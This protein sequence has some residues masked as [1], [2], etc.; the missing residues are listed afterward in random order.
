[1]QRFSI[2]VPLLDDRRLFD[3]TLAS[4]LRYRPENSQI[5][6]PHDGTYDDPFDLDG[7]VEFVSTAHR[8]NQV[9]LFNIAVNKAAGDYIAWIRP[10]IEL[11]SGW[12]EHV[13]LKFDNTE[14]ASVTPIIVSPAHPQR[15]VAA[16]VNTG[17]G[18]N[19]QVAGSRARLAPRTFRRISAVGPTSW[20]AFYRKSALDQIGI[21]AEQIDPH[22]LDVDIAMSLRRIGF[23]SELCSDC[24]LTI[25]RA[26][27]LERESSV[28]H[29]K[30]AQRGYYRYADPSAPQRSA[31][32]S[33][34][35]VVGDM[36]MSLFLPWKF[37]HAMGRMGAWKMRRA[38][39]D[40]ADHL[41]EISSQRN[42]DDD[43]NL[44][45]RPGFSGSRAQAC[46]TRRAA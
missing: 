10:G 17:V 15:I 30:S 36:L 20:A 23:T 18:Y 32:K 29:G 24:V 2:I 5:I 40:Y 43:S 28:P 11:D 34:S 1:M 39:L 31:A 33:V 12:A 6:V 14:V 42:Q 38:D 8:S 16:G 9:D 3:D 46:S 25:E 21:F 45:S 22:F 26:S 4:V 7:E 19:R 41:L 37:R 13:A 44:R 27:L 35:L